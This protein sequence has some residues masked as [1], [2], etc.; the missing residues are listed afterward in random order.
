MQACGLLLPAH[1]R[2]PCGTRHVCNEVCCLSECHILLIDLC[3]PILPSICGRS[4]LYDQTPVNAFPNT[5]AV[6][7]TDSGACHE[8]PLTRCRLRRG[9]RHNGVRCMVFINPETS[10]HAGTLGHVSSAMLI[11]C[12]L[13]C[14]VQVIATCNNRSLAWNTV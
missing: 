12:H 6:I 7:F 5:S 10:V 9:M 4:G 13:M 8:A 1:V 14:L 2:T 3:N 11:V